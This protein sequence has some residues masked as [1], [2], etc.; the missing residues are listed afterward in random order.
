ML[1][2]NYLVA[3]FEGL[4]YLS[5]MTLNDLENEYER[6]RMLFRGLRVMMKLSQVEAAKTMGVSIG[7]VQNFE[8][9]KVTPHTET[10]VRFQKQISQW[11]VE[12]GRENVEALAREKGS[13]Y[14]PATIVMV[15]NFDCPNCGALTPGP[16][17]NGKVEPLFCGWCGH[18]LGIK[19]PQCGAVETRTGKHFCGE[20]GAKLRP[21]G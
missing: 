13:Q 2:D 4:C 17:G 3:V 15:A 10:L 19:C 9:G 1:C 14:R 6:A 5:K 12:V 7:T 11:E 8:S 21:E 16:V 18:S 20:C